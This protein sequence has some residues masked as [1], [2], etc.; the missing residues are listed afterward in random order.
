[1]PMQLLLLHF[2]TEQRKLRAIGCLISYQSE[3]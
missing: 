1:M 3:E 2:A